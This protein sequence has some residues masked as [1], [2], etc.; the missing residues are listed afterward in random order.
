MELKVE[1]REDGS[2]HVAN[3]RGRLADNVVALIR[4]ELFGMV[5]VAIQGISE[6]EDQGGAV[7]EAEHEIP[8]FPG[9]KIEMKITI[10][11]F[12]Q[13][14]IDAMVEWKEARDAA[15]ED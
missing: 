2:I 9:F 10:P 13:D 15:D 4:E 12:T 8:D 3:T 14:M 6:H 7:L 5:G 1:Q 11:W